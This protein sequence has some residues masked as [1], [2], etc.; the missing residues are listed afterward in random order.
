MI[1]VYDSKEDDFFP[2]VFDKRKS[3]DDM[4]NGIKTMHVK[5]VEASLTATQFIV[6]K[7]DIFKA[8]KK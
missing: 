5:R 8:K 7:G 3:F 2:F 1:I 6:N 4:N